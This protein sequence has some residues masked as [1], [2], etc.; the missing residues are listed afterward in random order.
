MFLDQVKRVRNELERISG[1]PTVFVPSSSPA[2]AYPFAVLR[3]QSLV[4]VGW[5]DPRV[6]E[7]IYY[8]LRK[9]AFTYRI[10][11][12][13]NRQTDP[14]FIHPFER[15]NDVL[16]VLSD[17]VESAENLQRD[18]IA[19]VDAGEIRD[20]SGIV[21]EG[22]EISAECDLI[23]YFADIKILSERAQD[24]I[25]DVDIQDQITFP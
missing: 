15:M 14:T 20:T 6:G 13:E 7:G 9:V 11:D 24:V 8:T 12:S 21:G 10:Q 3:L 16:T 23:F 1:I 25:E 18:N 5:D 17:D 2:P 22:Y 4:P 19:F